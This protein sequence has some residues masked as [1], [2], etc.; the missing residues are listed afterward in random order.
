LPG[1]SFSLELPASLG[2]LRSGAPREQRL[3]KQPRSAATLPRAPPP[4]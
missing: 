2:R 3:A 4:A 1:N